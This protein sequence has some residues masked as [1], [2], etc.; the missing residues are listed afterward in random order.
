[1]ECLP[2]HALLLGSWLHVSCSVIDLEVAQKNP[3]NCW[4]LVGRSHLSAFGLETCLQGGTLRM[5]GR[6]DDAV[7]VRVHVAIKDP[8]RNTLCILA[9]HMLASASARS[10]YTTE[11][12]LFKHELLQ[13]MSFYS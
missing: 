2:L 10:M 8:G 3:M 4:T 6:Y 1:M 13:S 12:R 5:P 11:S 7:V 9:D